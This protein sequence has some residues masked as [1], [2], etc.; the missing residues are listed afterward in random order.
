MIMMDISRKYEK[1]LIC[2]RG[3]MLSQGWGL[4]PIYLEKAGFSIHHRFNRIY[5][6]FGAYRGQW[7]KYGVTSDGSSSGV[8]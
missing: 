3:P 1:W 5:K 8:D 2:N 7:R 6:Y 4:A